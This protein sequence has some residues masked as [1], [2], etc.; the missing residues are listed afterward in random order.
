[1]TSPR[2]WDRRRNRSARLQLETLEDRR[3]PAS[4]TVQPIWGDGAVELNAHDHGLTDIDSLPVP[5]ILANRPNMPRGLFAFNVTN[6]MPGGIAIVDLTMPS[7]SQPRA[8]FKQDPVTG[9]LDRFDWDGKTGAKIAGDRVTLYL[10]DGGRGDADGI[11]NG[12]VVDPGGPGGLG[13]GDPGGGGLG[14]GDPGG[15]G[16]GGPGGLGGGGGGTTGG[17]VISQVYGSGGVT[18]AVY[19]RDFIELFN[20]TSSSISLSGK[21]VQYAGTS[22]GSWTVLTL[23][24]SISSGHY[25]LIGGASGSTGAAL[26]TVDQ[27]ASVNL[28]DTGGKVALVDGTTALFGA[29]PFTTVIDHV[30]YGDADW[31]EGSGTAPASDAADAALRLG[32]G[33]YDTNDNQWD[34]LSDTPNPRNSSSSA[35][36]L[37]PHVTMPSTTWTAT[38]TA[39]TVTGISVSDPDAGMNSLAITV[40]ADNG[41][42]TLAST[43][44]LTF[45]DGDGTAD[46]SMTFTGTLTNIGSALSGLTYTPETGYHGAAGISVWADDQG[47]SGVGGSLFDAGVVTI[48]TGGQIVAL[49]E[50]VDGTEDTAAMID[51]RANDAWATYSTPALTV[52]TSPSHGT[53]VVDNNGTFMDSSDDVIKYTPSAEWHGTDSFTYQLSDGMFNTTTATVTVTVAQV[54]DAF[55]ATTG[56]ENM[57]SD[58]GESV[59][60]RFDTPDATESLTWTSTGLPTGLSLNSSTGVISGRAQYDQAGAHSVTLTA[61]GGDGDTFTQDLTWNVSDVNRLFWQDNIFSQAG[62]VVV[63]NTMANDQIGNTLTYTMTGLPNGI[64]IDSSTGLYSGYPGQDTYPNVDT[65]VGE[66]DV[67]LTVTGGGATDVRAFHWTVVSKDYGGGH[68]NINATEIHEDDLGFIGKPLPAWVHSFNSGLPVVV[69]VMS[70][71]A[72]LSLDPSADPVGSSE[73]EFPAQNVL[74][75]GGVFYIIPKLGSVSNDDIVVVANR[76]NMGGGETVIGAGTINAVGVEI[77]TTGLNAAGETNKE[78]LGIIAAVDTPKEMLKPES[79][80]YRIPPRKWD[81]TKLWVKITAG[82]LGEKSIWL[83]APFAPKNAPTQLGQSDLNGRVAL[84]K[85]GVDGDG[86]ENLELKANAFTGG[87]ASL[88]IRGHLDAKLRPSPFQTEPGNDGR[89]WLGLFSKNE[90]P[91]GA[92]KEMAGAYTHGFSV[93]A[94]P[95]GWK[96][97]TSVKLKEKVQIGT[98]DGQ[99]VFVTLPGLAKFGSEYPTAYLSGAAFLAALGNS[100]GVLFGAAYFNTWI[101]DS[102]EMSDL[103]QAFTSE[104]FL[105]TRPGDNTGVFTNSPADT[106]EGVF[107]SAGAKPALEQTPDFIGWG[108]KVPLTSNSDSKFAGRIKFHSALIKLVL[109]KKVN[110]DDGGSSLSRQYAE[111]YDARTGMTATNAVPVANSGFKVTHSILIVSPTRIIFSVEKDPNGWTVTA[112][113]S[114]TE[115]GPGTITCTKEFDTEISS[116]P[117]YDYGN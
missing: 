9:T 36:N 18:D 110:A 12:V 81:Q 87:S 25:F 45:S 101:S 46:T 21:S 31:F 23:S 89:L 58:E 90:N 117:S 94:I 27:S 92:T 86:L 112:R 26:P 51:V 99:P 39:L 54:N 59:N 41:T 37:R 5:G 15:G 95:V 67:T 64:T 82:T 48:V 80:N 102:G 100:T 11:A 28:A 33:N 96:H 91:Y 107:R 52:A 50:S 75:N 69:R 14:G 13:G 85:E 77:G 103:D 109:G 63:L 74:G 8:Y 35:A 88:S 97:E 68:V 7:G 93:A 49:D 114:T 42:I 62:Q 4:A 76:E 78:R 32:N 3:Q 47:N 108:S 19:N 116:D 60:V 20:P 24:G 40:S 1:M 83:I 2:Q 10:Q 53:A 61:T 111:F 6:V 70:D 73:I 105:P 115:V 71:K 30:G 98:K 84:K 16:G 72:T 43:T 79:P 65:S 34:F 38:N 17:L 104:A 55:I 22:S 56:D 57:Y 29:V 44:G 66:Y 106:S 113:G